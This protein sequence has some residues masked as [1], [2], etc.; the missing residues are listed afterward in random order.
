MVLIIILI[1]VVVYW[2][3]FLKN[4]QDLLLECAP[5]NRNVSP[6]SVWFLL[7]PVFNIFYSLILFPSVGDT[8]QKE[9]EQRGR[10]NTNKG[11]LKTIGTL[12]AVLSFVTIG[13]SFIAFFPESFRTTICFLSASTQF[14][15][16]K[17][18]WV[19]TDNYKNQLKRLP[20]LGNG[21]STNSELLD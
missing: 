2:V 18:Y 11:S 15:L 3:L 5:H 6:T 1:A 16:L 20:R 12:I 8:I 10:T 7:I 9:F 19:M 4:L 17:V 13:I 21:F 14:I